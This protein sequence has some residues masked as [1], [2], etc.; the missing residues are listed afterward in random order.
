MNDTR[1]KPNSA[2]WEP[3]AAF[4]CFASSVVALALGFTFTTD[5][6][7]NAARHPFLHGVGITLL[8][9]GIPL[10]ILGGHCLDLMDKKKKLTR[11]VSKIEVG[12]V[13]RETRTNPNGAMARPDNKIGLRNAN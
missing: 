12:Q 5:W 1:V 8:I 10:L 4:A 9:I 13:T 6:L 11:A 3:V 7:L 2:T